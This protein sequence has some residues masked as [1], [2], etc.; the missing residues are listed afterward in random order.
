VTAFGSPHPE[1]K[2][3]AMFLM[4]DFVSL[5][6][7]V[8]VPCTVPVARRIMWPGSVAHVD[9]RSEGVRLGW[10]SASKVRAVGVEG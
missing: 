10:I 4:K 1:L 6:A 8:V 5:R 7:S 9:V 3:A 2:L